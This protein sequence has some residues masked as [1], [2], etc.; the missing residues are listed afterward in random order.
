M[1]RIGSQRQGLLAIVDNRNNNN[2][3]SRCG[4]MALQLLEQLPRMLSPQQHVQNNRGWPH[5]SQDFASLLERSRRNDLE[6]RALENPLIDEH[7]LAVIFHN[8]YRQSAN[9][10]RLFKLQR[11][12]RFGFTG[13]TNGDAGKKYRTFPRVTLHVH[14]AAKHL[15]EFP[16]QWQAQ[17]ASFDRA[18]LLPFDLRPLLKDALL[19]FL[20]DA[21]SRVGDRKH[22]R[23]AVAA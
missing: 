15:R 8:K 9:P 1:K 19:V 3:N 13:K 23:V 20:S 12:K 17:P 18:L 4:R 6:A 2:R 22:Q 21:D 7:L 14:I 16:G 10:A 11:I 5:R